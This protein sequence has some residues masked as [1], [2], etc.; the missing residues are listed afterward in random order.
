MTTDAENPAT[1]GRKEPMTTTA[2]LSPDRAFEKA[3][4]EM[5]ALPAQPCA[6]S[7]CAPRAPRSRAKGKQ[8]KARPAPSQPQRKQRKGGTP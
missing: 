5:W 6:C 7:I 4:R 1:T 3:L 2:K 8:A